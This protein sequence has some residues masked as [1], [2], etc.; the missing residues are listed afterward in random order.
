MARLLAYTWFTLVVSLTG[1]LGDTT[2]ILKLRGVLVRWCFRRSGRNLQIASGVRICF[3][4]RMSVGKDVYIAPGCWIQAAGGVELGD[5]VMLGPYTVLAT[6]NHTRVD[7]SYRFGGG[8]AAPIVLGR[9][10]WTGAHVVITA[11]VRVGDGAAIAAG[12]VVTGDV[13]D[14]VVVGGVPARP[15]SAPADIRA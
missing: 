9:G 13:P 15:I 3:T 7:G 6:N 4:T 1:F 5:Q 10:S 11:G 8:A 14:G 12:A 2:P